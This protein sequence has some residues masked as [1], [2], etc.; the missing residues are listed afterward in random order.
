MVNNAAPGWD[1]FVQ[2]PGVQP[3]LGI[4]C[5]FGVLGSLALRSV[6]STLDVYSAAVYC[7][8]VYRS[9]SEGGR[10]VFHFLFILNIRGWGHALTPDLFVVIVSTLIKV[11]PVVWWPATRQVTPR[12]PNN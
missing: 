12:A 5:L 3:M 8:H 7:T 1:L 10:R 4:R 6:Q 2:D 11:P 9:V